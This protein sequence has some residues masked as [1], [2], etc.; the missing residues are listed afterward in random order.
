MTTSRAKI[1]LLIILIL[2]TLG[3]GLAII[4]RRDA[5]YRRQRAVEIGKLDRGLR[6]H[7]Q[8]RD[9]AAGLARSLAQETDPDAQTRLRDQLEELQ[10]QL[11]GLRNLLHNVL[12]R[13]SQMPP[14]WLLRE[15]A[16]L[17]VAALRRELDD[18]SPP[19]RP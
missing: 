10:G 9:L 5:D 2:A 13:Y 14:P 17:D 15:A 19:A 7:R 6:I 3:L 18:G 4:G 16:T 11:D 1:F 8:Y 12:D